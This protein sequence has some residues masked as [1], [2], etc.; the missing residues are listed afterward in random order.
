LSLQARAL[1]T[2]GLS[3]LL[4]MAL[5]AETSRREFFA[6]SDAKTAGT[7]SPKTAAAYLDQ[8]ADWWM[9]WPRAARDHGTF[10]VSCHTVL[11]YA[12][13]RAVLR[14]YVVSGFSPAPTVGL[15]ALG[16]SE[17]KS[18][19]PYED[20][21]VDN[22]AKRVRLWK[23]VGPYY[24]DYADKVAESRGTEAVLN[25]LILADH[26]AQRGRLS[27]DTRT[28]LDNMW[29]LQQTTGDH[30]GAWPWLQFGLSPW[31]GRDSQYYGAALAALAAGL[32][33]EHYCSTVAIQRN[34]ELLRAYLAREYP[35]Q[36]LSNRVVLLWASTELPGLLGQEPQRL[37]V[38]E[39]LGE[40]QADG[41]WSL[42][43]LSGSSRA[44]R[45]RS[46][47]RSLMRHDRT[48]ME[49][50]SDGYAT[51]LVAFTLLRLETPRESVPLQKGLAWLMRNQNK[52]D[53]S[54]P[55]S[56][57]NTR[58]DPSSDIGRFMSDAATG[59][60]VLALT[61]A[62]RVPTQVRQDNQVK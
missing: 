31:E 43:S 55:A 54:W 42:A 33:P 29:A 15:P 24:S 60:A 21:L 32:A 49:T 38:S 26:D 12:L 22:V 39:I 35:T 6:V 47:V 51:G 7:W 16:S 56:S 62:N 58:R 34:L 13:S 25:A 28:A 5:V 37:L 44:S 48:L 61:A 3:A 4:V 59:F 30:A 36:P 40:Q 27:G 57:P 19:T 11:P 10:C 1:A 2:W 23:E 9:R 17:R 50:R 8:R 41:G 52:T 20:R 53:G 18:D 46:Y 14:S 45:L